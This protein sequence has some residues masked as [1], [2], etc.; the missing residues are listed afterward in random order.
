MA[1]NVPRRIPQPVSA[2]RKKDCVGSR[3]IITLRGDV[4]LPQIPMDAF[5]ATTTPAGVNIPNFLLRRGLEDPTPPTVVS[6]LYLPPGKYSITGQVGFDGSNLTDAQNTIDLAFN[7]VLG[8]NL[9]LPGVVRYS[10]LSGGIAPGANNAMPVTF[11][12]QL[13]EE[14]RVTLSVE[15]T[16]TTEI[17]ADGSPTT[18]AADFAGYVELTQKTNIMIVRIG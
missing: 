13:F 7:I 6:G 8:D 17:T 12:K 3:W 18:P 9:E 4:D 16:N 5:P 1:A 11:Y 2:P 14:T 15:F 10:S